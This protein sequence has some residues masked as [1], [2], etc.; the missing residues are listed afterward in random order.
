VPNRRQL[1]DRAGSDSELH[2]PAIAALAVSAFVF[3]TAET[4]PVGLLPQIAHGLSVS[5][6]DVGLLLTTYA[7]VAAVSTIPLTALTMR[8]PRHR[9]IAVLVAIFAVSQFAASVAPTFVVLTIA[10]LLCALAHGVFWSAIAPAAA[11]LAPPGHAGRATSLVF[12]GNS[13]ALVLGVPLGTALGQLA[14][15]RIA[16]AVLGCAGAVSSAAL[17]IYLPV[18]SA[19]AADLAAGTLTRM[20]NATRIIRSRAITPVCAVT[21]VLVVGQFAAYTYIDPL[22][23]R[24]G[25]LHGFG[26]SALLFGYG[27]AGL[28]SNVL[29]GRL[30][31]RRPGPALARSVLMVA[32]ALIVLAFRG[33]TFVTVIA[34]VAWG[35]GFVA[36]PVS[37]QAAILRVAPEAQEA[38]SAVYVVAFQIGIASGALVGNRFVTAGDLGYLPVA[39]AALAIVAVAVVFGARRAFPRRTYQP[40]G[41]VPSSTA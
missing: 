33:G 24:D 5:Q 16:L 20:R 31:D 10:R 15:W 39:G 32:A 2:V 30:V 6:A 28:A 36:V 27:I 38:A 18:L 34:V 3:V 9:L 41:R 40:R 29:V 13:A 37:L 1:R 14:G 11:R 17:W 26:L 21:T 23:L 12:V 19:S 7:A 8:I 25:G 35:A 22:V 4:L